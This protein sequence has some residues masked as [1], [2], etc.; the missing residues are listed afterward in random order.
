[1]RRSTFMN[2]LNSEGRG[3][4]D[5]GEQLRPVPGLAQAA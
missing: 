1:M 4:G 3:W 2:S 5:G